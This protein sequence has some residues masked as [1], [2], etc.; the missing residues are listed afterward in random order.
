[1]YSQHKSLANLVY[2]V[3]SNHREPNILLK[4]RENGMK[5]LTLVLVMVLVLTVS[6]ASH[7]EDV[8]IPPLDITSDTWTGNMGYINVSVGFYADGTYKLIQTGGEELTG[9]KYTLTEEESKESEQIGTYKLTSNPDGSYGLEMEYSDAITTEEGW[10]LL[11]A[12]DYVG[13]IS[14]KNGQWYVRGDV[15]MSTSDSRLPPDL[16]QS[17]LV[18]DFE[19]TQVK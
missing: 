9:D 14:F 5:R 17:S 7:K 3:L 4:Q 16:S 10:V 13:N 15:T 19:W 2:I 8:K 12:D 1:M 11:I 18:F 6:C